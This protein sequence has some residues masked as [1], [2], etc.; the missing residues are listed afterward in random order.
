MTDSDNSKSLRS[1][2]GGL[3]LCEPDPPYA[4]YAGIYRNPYD[5]RL[6]RFSMD[7]FSLIEVLVVIMLISAGILPIYS[8]MKSGQ[9]RI[10]RA[11][12]RVMA[13]LFG[14]TAL[15]LARTLGYDRSQKLDQDKDYLEV[16]ANANKNGFNIEFLPTMQPLLPMPPGAKPMFL[17][18]IQIVVSPISRTFSDSP[19][20]KF[21]TILSDPRYNYY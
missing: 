16:K 17:L 4:P 14:T 8:L 12:T 15:E 11:D 7:G 9:K 10:V 19:T 21:V 20:L 1:L 18:R 13:T 3:R 6:H 5:K 2:G